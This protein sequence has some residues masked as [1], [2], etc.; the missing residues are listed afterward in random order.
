MLTTVPPVYFRIHLSSHSIY[1]TGCK[2]YPSGRNMHLCG[3]KGILPTLWQANQ[4]LIDQTPSELCNV[5]E[6]HLTKLTST[7][8]TVE[9][10][11]SLLLKQL[12]CYRNIHMY[13]F[14]DDAEHHH[15]SQCKH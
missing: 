12:Y 15:G 14:Y 4:L 9:D 3:R 11:S 10:K 6:T 13:D 8:L 2:E 1:L 5:K 7:L